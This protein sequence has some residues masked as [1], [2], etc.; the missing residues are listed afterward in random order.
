VS[1]ALGLL[2]KVMPDMTESMI[3]GAEEDGSIGVTFKT[4]Y[5]KA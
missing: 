2:K 1:A 4:V 3:K 5:D